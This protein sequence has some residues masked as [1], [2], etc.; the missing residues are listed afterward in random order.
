MSWLR[1]G[2][3]DDGRTVCDLQLSE[4]EL[5]LHAG[6][7]NHALEI[8]LALLGR[9][10][11]APD[12]RR[13]ARQVHARA[14]EATGALEQAI[15]VLSDLVEADEAN[16]EAADITIVIALSRCLRESGDIGAA[17]DAAT[18]VLRRLEADGAPVDDTRIEL[19]ATLVGAYNERGDYVLGRRLAE[20]TIASADRLGTPRSRGSAY[21]NAMLIAVNDGRLPDAARYAQRALS[22]Y[23]E[24]DASRNLSRLKV[25]YA[26]LLLRADPPE[27]EKALRVL[28]AVGPALRDEGSV[29]DQAYAATE[30]ARALVQLD[31]LPR[32]AEAAQSAAD[33]LASTDALEP[34]EA[35]RAQAILALIAYRRGDAANAAALLGQA[36]R[37]LWDIGASRPAAEVWRELGE[38]AALAGDAATATDAFR[39]ALDAV[40]VTAPVEPATLRSRSGAN[41]PR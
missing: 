7:P 19:A 33:L 30:R 4:A 20:R 26:W 9:P 35:A 40:G 8:S 5:D 11:L 14:L 37:M 31:D 13:R 39:N 24:T 2:R 6:Q 22:L 38:V 28:D 16:G 18:R 29:V 27:P 32:A 41:A 25:A 15:D 23:G 34:I 17:I 12:L 1:T 3:S 21:W 10:E 36:A